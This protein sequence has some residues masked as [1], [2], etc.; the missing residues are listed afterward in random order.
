MQNLVITNS[1]Q[2]L[3]SKLIAGTTTA[4]FTKIA[5]SDHDYSDVSL[6]GV[7]ELED[8]KQTA[9]ISKVSRTDLTLVEVLA[10]L[11][12]SSLT[13]GYYV[14][15]LGLY[16]KDGD[17]TEI[18]YAISIEPTTPDY[19]PAFSGKTVSSI[20]YRLITKVDNSEQVTLE[21]NAGAFPTIEQLDNFQRI[22]FF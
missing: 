10:A 8:V 7:T 5:G 17:G 11:D 3:M 22:S 2:E 18:L 13:E 6:E 4:T 20:T 12:N 15:A 9:L 21:V 16:A 19:L 1:G 14:R